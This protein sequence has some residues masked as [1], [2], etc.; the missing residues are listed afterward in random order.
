MLMLL[1]ADPARTPARADD[2][3]QDQPAAEA[4]AAAVPEPDTLLAEAKAKLDEEAWEEAE[5]RYAR[6]FETYP[7]HEAAPEARFWAGFCEMKLG[8]SDEAIERLKPFTESLADN[9]WADDALLHLGRAYREKGD[10]EAARGTW[11]R[12][13]EHYPDSPWRSEVLRETVDL[14]F[15]DAGD[16]VAC[17]DACRHAVDEI[18]DLQANAEA[19]YRGAYCLNAL[20]RFDESAAWANERLR[21]DS[22]LEEGWHLVLE[23]QRGLLEGQAEDAAPRAASLLDRFPDLAPPERADL[24]TRLVDALRYNGRSDQAR[25]LLLNAITQAPGLVTDDLQPLFDQ[26]ENLLGEARRPDYLAELGQIAASPTTPLL[27]RIVAR[28]RHARAMREAGHSEEAEAALRAPLEA[29]A[30]TELER[31]HAALSLTELLVDDRA[32]RAAAI[33]LLTD[34][35]PRLERRDLKHRAQTRLDELNDLALAE[36]AE[37]PPAKAESP[38]EPPKPE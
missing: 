8:K 20:R 4:P 27:V 24:T 13:L 16:I 23:I 28:D 34:V 17:L 6:L 35:I 36:T 7:D 26:L 22:P 11:E 10:T 30:T 37:P 31:V 3:P 15:H 33:A 9:T 21:D 1:V 38:A 14:L 2:P 19:R 18:E 25:T 5:G 29:D 12:Q 32:D